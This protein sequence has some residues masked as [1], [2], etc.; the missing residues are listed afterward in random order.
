MLQRLL[1]TDEDELLE[2]YELAESY[3]LRMRQAGISIQGTVF[4]L[5]PGEQYY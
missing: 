1:D 5:E 2:L 4:D 3:R